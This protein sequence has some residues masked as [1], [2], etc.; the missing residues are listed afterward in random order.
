[1]VTPN[2]AIDW[3]GL[4]SK[5]AGPVLVAILAAFLAAKLAVNRFYK[6]KWW[7]KR[8]ASF[9]EV[10][11]LSYRIK[12]TNDYFLEIES[13]K[14]NLQSREFKRHKPEVELQLTSQYWT[15]LQ[16]IERISQLSEFTLTMNASNII[17]DFLKGRK[18][19]R[20]S[21]NEGE[22][23]SFEASDADY[24]VSVRLLDSLVAEAK[25]ELKVK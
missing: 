7:E 15:D 25:R 21:F 23:T 3:V 24:A 19:I 18:S 16:E 13:S 1:M 10:I 17:K 5:S 12:M 9:T 22:R 14:Q 2:D 11:E 6:E 4:A 20:E 8:L